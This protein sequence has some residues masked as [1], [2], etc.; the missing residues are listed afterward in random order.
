MALSQV[1]E[2]NLE[3]VWQRVYGHDGKS[4]PKFRVGDRVQISKGVRQFKKGHMATT[5]DQSG[6]RI[7][8]SFQTHN[9]NYRRV[10]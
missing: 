1:K 9:V 2:S 3:E 6:S 4:A 5:H 10:V 7:V 8:Y